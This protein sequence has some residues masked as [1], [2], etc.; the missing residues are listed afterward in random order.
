[1]E[2]RLLGPLEV[3]GD[4]GRV[5][6][7]PGAKLSG[8]L[9]LLALHVGDVVPTTRII[10]DLWGEREIRDPVNAAQVLV[11]YADWLSAAAAGAS[12]E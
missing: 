10:E 8:L 6:D 9:V 3:I 7:V 1:M 12:N 2:L 5:V 11:A 4:D